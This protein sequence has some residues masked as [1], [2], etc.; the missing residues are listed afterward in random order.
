M[1]AAR[2]L[3]SNCLTNAHPSVA[4]DLFFL[5]GSPDPALATDW[6]QSAR[7]FAVLML[8]LTIRV[9]S[10]DS[11]FRDLTAS[12]GAS[13]SANSSHQFRFAE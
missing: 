12:P 11:A 9:S 3:R 2:L 1:G 4:P 10:H 7:D 8:A 5:R 13:R 6:R